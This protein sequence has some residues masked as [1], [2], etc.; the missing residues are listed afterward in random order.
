M[1]DPAEEEVMLVIM[2]LAA[3][4]AS[5][6]A[7]NAGLAA[8][9]ARSRPPVLRTERKYPPGGYREGPKKEFAIIATPGDAARQA[10][11]ANA[12]AMR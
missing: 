6:I 3:V 4:V 8:A 1:T 11:Y 5:T 7:A 12:R 2:P 10:I 9:A